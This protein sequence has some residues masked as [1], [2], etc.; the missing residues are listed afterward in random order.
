MSDETTA[1]A[2]KPA[3]PKWFVDLK[4]RVPLTD[5]DKKNAPN[6]YPEGYKEV[7]CSE[8]LEPGD[9][10]QLKGMTIIK[11]PGIKKICNKEGIVEKEFRTEI[12]PTEGNK[13]QHGVNIWVG[14]KGDNDK[15]NWKR[16]SGEASQLNT[17]KVT[18]K[19]DASGAEKTM[20][21]EYNPIDSKYRFAMAD[22]R[23][24]CRAVLSL[25]E[26]VGVYAEVESP[27][28]FYKENGDGTPPADYNY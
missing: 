21:D 2:N 14:F 7:S 23:A 20:Y 9:M 27:E 15:D 18:K 19:K 1:S 17:G 8:T 22:K 3:L 5:Q 12:L 11:L 4:Y 28:F 6:L 16:G 25:V 24:F 13:Q 10:Y 26:L